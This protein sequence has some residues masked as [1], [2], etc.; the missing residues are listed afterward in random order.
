[1]SQRSSCI[2]QTASFVI[3]RALCVSQGLLCRPIDLLCWSE[4]LLCLPGSLLCR[5]RAS[6]FCQRT[7]R[8]GHGAYCSERASHVSVVVLPMSVKRAFFAARVPPISATGPPVSRMCPS[9]RLECSS[10]LSLSIPNKC[11]YCTQTLS[12][13]GWQC[14]P[15]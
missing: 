13:K 4:G 6:Y 14:H 12:N 1:M 2:H 11:R 15:S 9:Y 7:S 10:K 8:I 3:H 5:S